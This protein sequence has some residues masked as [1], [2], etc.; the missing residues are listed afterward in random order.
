MT[1][2]GVTE[3]LRAFKDQHLIFVEAETDFLITVDEVGRVVYVNPAVEERL[4]RRRAQF[5]HHEIAQFINENDL[6]RFIHSFDKSRDPEPIRFLK[7]GNGEVAAT[8]IN[9]IFQ[10]NEEN[11]L[12]GYLL[13]R[14]VSM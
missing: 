9:F 11:K 5:L 14:P 13:F 6:A 1:K 12:F 4:E 7:W 3:F 10:Q 2:H 8:M